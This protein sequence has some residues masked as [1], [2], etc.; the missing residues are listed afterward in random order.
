MM[1][2]KHNLQLLLSKEEISAKIKELA[3]ELN[4]KYKDNESLSFVA[5]MNGSLFFFTD[6][7]KQ[8]NIPIKMDTVTVSSYSGMASTREV[9]FHKEITKPIV[10]GQD[11]IIIED[12]I[13]TGLTLTA[14][15]EHILA[16]KP[17][18]LQIITLGDKTPCHPD[19]KYEYKT[20]FDFPNKFVVG[21]GL[22]TDDL[23]RQ[24]PEIYYV[25]D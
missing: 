5:I 4:E 6:L 16:L 8:I 21:Y 15:Y 13:D 25:V 14:V 7:L 17:K 9:T 3:E 20:L 12:L 10:E 2:F 22:E 24:L 11:V 18:T 19:F 23:Y 1:K